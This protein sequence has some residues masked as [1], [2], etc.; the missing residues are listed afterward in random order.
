M[1][2][3]P[4][5][6]EFPSLRRVLKLRHLL[7]YGMIVIQPT[8]PLSSFGIVSTVAQGH[9]ATIILLAMVAMVLTAFSYGRMAA[10]YPKAGSA[11]SYVSHEL[12]PNLGFLTGWSIAMDYV[13]NPTIGTIWCAKA[14]M[15][16]L[17]LPFPFWVVLFLAL[18][19]WLNL[20]GIETNAKTNTLLTGAIGVV[21]LVFFVAATGYLVRLGGWGALFST[22]PFYDPQTFSWPLV[23]TGAS[24]AVLTYMG[25]DSV[26][27][28]SEDV[29]D[30]KRNILLASVL[31]CVITGLLGTLQ[32][33]Y[34]QLVWPDYQNFP[35]PDT[36]FVAAAGRAG[37]T[38]LFQLVNAALLVATMGS[39]LGAQLGAG[40]LLY[41]MGRDNVI[42]KGF[43][44]Y[45]DPVHRTPRNA[46]LLSGGLCV[47]GALTMSFQTGA[48][49]LNFGAFVAFMGVNAAAMVHYYFRNPD[50]G[51]K[52]VFVN[53]LPPLLG[54]LV[55]FYIWW[56][57]RDGA[58]LLGAAW[59]AVG[60]AYCAWKTQGFRRPIMLPDD[61]V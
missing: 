44:G 19:T 55:C 52:S 7:L 59:L 13:L 49:L 42:P 47:I 46:I 60:L 6:N 16:I 53:L 14:A 45:L 26:S 58:K 56:S 50:K 8:A 51:F 20:R 3:P 5:S 27:T 54:F 21:L 61:R 31:L 35:D 39:S 28:L 23:S 15:N 38:W 48:E 40:R 10:V 1:S 2:T 18:F 41:A 4:N 33:Y 25:F 12:H 36:A 32:V 9:V 29:E 43:F 24:I 17:P 11:F 37:G 30:P 22:K 34:G 57:L